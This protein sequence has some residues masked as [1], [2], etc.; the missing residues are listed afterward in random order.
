M[1]VRSM[2]RRIT[3]TKEMHKKMGKTGARAQSRVVSKGGR[4]LS[5]ASERIDPRNHVRIC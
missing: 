2:G 5:Y 3:L 4:P 1:T